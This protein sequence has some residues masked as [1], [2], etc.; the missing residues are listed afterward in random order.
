MDDK[1]EG[2]R[3]SIYNCIDPNGRV[4][5]STADTSTNRGFHYREAT[6]G[7]KVWGH[8]TTHC[9]LGLRAVR[10]PQCAISWF[11]T[12]GNEMPIKISTDHE[13]LI[14]FYLRLTL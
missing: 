2:S 5:P 9:I 6:R 4:L 7:K 3:S 10:N 11:Q 13:N 12:D 8:S 1:K 14:F